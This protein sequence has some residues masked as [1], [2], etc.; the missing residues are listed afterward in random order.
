MLDDWLPVYYP[1]S[2]AE[3]GK[4]GFDIKA[5]QIAA[6]KAVLLQHPSGWE[7]QMLADENTNRKNP[8]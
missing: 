7:R 2:A 6:G 3:S 5:E 4:G 8:W 1:S